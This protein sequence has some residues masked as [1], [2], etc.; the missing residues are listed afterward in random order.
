MK[1]LETNIMR[2]PNYWSN[3]HHKL[4]VTKL[5]IEAYEE[6]PTNLIPEFTERLE[7]LLP[8]LYGHRCSYDYEGGFFERLR[9][10]TWMGHVIEHIA[11]ELQCLAGM[12]C[13]FGRTRG[14][15][16]N[17]V[18]N[19]V[20]A[21]EIESAGLYA[22][23]TAIQLALALA[24]SKLF[25]LEIEL[26][27]LRS[28]KARYGVGPS[29]QSIITEALKRGIPYRSMENGSLILFG[30]G[31]NQKLIRASLT[32]NTS[33]FGVETAGDK[34]ETKRLLE[35]AFIPVPKWEVISSSEELSE[36]IRK[37]QFPLVIKPINGNHGRGITTNILT[38]AQA[39]E[40][41]DFAKTISGELIVEQFISGDDYRLLVINYKL[42]AAAKRTPAMVIG[43]G[44]STI[45]Q[46]IEEINRDPRRGEGHENVLTRIK[47]DNLTEQLLKRKNLN[48]SSVL[49]IGEV[50]FV[51]DT[52]NLSTGGTAMDV[53]DIVSAETKFLAERA[54]RLINLDVC[55]IDVVAKD[56]ALPLDG[57]NG[58]VIEVNACPGLRMH[59]SP[60][61]GLSRNVAEPLVDMLYPPR[62]KSRIPLVAVTGTNGKTTTTRLTAHIA[63]VAGHKTGFTTTDGIYIQDYLIHQGDCTGSLSGATVLMD[64]T[65]D[66]AVLECARGGILRNGLGFDKCDISIITNVTEDH[67]GLK[68][69]NTLDEMARVKEVVARSTFEH[70]WAI[71]NADDDR[72]YQMQEVLDCNIALF[73]ID[74]LNERIRKHSANGGLCATVEKDYLTILK[75]EWKIRICKIKSIPLSMDGRALA[76]I[77]NIFP[78]T[79]VGIISDFKIEDI[80]TALFSFVPSPEYTPGRMNLFHFRNFKILIDYAH[81]T[82]GFEE[83]RSFMAQV[84]CEQKMGIIAAVG[85]RRDEDIRNLGKLAAESFDTLII[86]H[87]ED[88]RGRTKEEL[89]EK[90]MEG[91]RLAAKTPSVIVISKEQEAIQYAMETCKIGAFIVLCTDQVQQ[92]I[93]YVKHKLKEEK[94]TFKI[95]DEILAQNKN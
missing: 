87:D 59:L 26:Q 43:N 82:G 52:A 93:Q 51:K 45:L 12:E 29:T 71:L 40:A 9:S 73:S 27:H 36:A 64:P 75:G 24:E 16:V 88:L 10:G 6:L 22:M 37:L 42:I 35:K 38:Q 50:L 92:S 78:A 34:D 8:S 70:G 48:L 74:P 19:I 84:N 47:V 90:L 68:D 94:E 2:G 41:F 79:L 25:N 49:P 33:H 46:L 77:K 72:V 4:I 85:D 76:M 60:T 13:G 18:Y 3:Y 56:I 20:I 44:E 89:T 21:Y 83:M 57:Q 69:I 67:L 31:A 23:K 14:A 58:A 39:S 61:K 86:R 54:A 80:R 5:D 91:I 28:V 15:G 1:I 55:G 53:T 32:C 17:G 30:Q 63:K 66:F 81:N 95:L 11:L 65:I 7:A 62:S